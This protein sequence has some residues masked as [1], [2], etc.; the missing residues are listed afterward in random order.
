[1]KLIFVYNAK[2]GTRNA[3]LDSLHKIL[4]PKTYSCSL[5]AITYGVFKIRPAWKAFIESSNLDMQ[6]YHTDEFTASFPEFKNGYR[7]PVVLKENG[8][9]FEEFIAPKELDVL[10]DDKELIDLIQVKINQSGVAR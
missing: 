7:F 2:S 5:C 8:K 1:M 4:R 6:F 9:G 10:T 3:W